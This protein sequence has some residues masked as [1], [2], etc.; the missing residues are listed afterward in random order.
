[1]PTVLDTEKREEIA[2][3]EGEGGIVVEPETAKI[4]PIEAA[5]SA[6]EATEKSAGMR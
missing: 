4:D 2:R 6:I 5:K 3:L 1:V